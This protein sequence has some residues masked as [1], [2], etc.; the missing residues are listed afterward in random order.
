MSIPILKMRAYTKLSLSKF[1]K[2]STY[3]IFFEFVSA[4]LPQK[5]F[6]EYKNHIVDT[7]FDCICQNV[8]IVLKIFLN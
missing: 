2:N 4:Q 8:A 1:N 5:L 6:R 3:I 7:S